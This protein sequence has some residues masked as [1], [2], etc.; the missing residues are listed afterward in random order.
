MPIDMNYDDPSQDLHIHFKA[1][2]QTLN[3]EQVEELVRFRHNNDGSTYPYEYGMEDYG[4][5]HTQRDL[6]TT[7]AKQTIQLKNVK[8]IGNLI[9]IIQKYVKTNMNLKELKDYAPYAL[10]MNTDNLK[11]GQLPGESKVLNGTWFFL[12]N[13]SETEELVNEL[14]QTANI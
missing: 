6:I 7:I 9:D 4:R 3:G 11:T 10:N 1:G 14:F 12:H 2:L 13:E 8:E 5:M